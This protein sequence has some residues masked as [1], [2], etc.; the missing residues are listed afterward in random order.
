[1]FFR[2]KKSG[3]RS[4]LQIV[5]NRWAGSGARQRVIATLGR[6][7]QLQASGEL[8]SLLRSGARFS[9][10][11]MVLGAHTQGEAPAL[12]SRR[13]GPAWVF[14]RLW[15]ET[16][17]RAVVESLLTERKFEFSVERAIF[18]TVLHRLF[19]PGSDR[20]ADKWRG[21]YAM[22]G[23]EGV[24]LHHL[25]RAMAWLGEELPEDSQ[26]G[27]TP[28]A[29]RCIKD[30]I[31]EHL[32][33]RRRDLFSSL[34]LVFFDTTSIYFEGRGGETI[35]RR[36]HSKDHRPD[37]PQMVVGAV[38]D[39]EGRPVCCELWPGNTADVR[40][41]LPLVER[42]RKRFAIGEICIVAD[43]GMISQETVAVLESGPGDFQYI[44][45][46]RMRHQKEVREEVLSRPGRYQV[47]HRKG[48]HS[49]AP[50]PLAVKEVQLHG[51]RYVVCFNEDQAKK[52]AADRDAIVS[53]LRERLKRG[54]KSL[55]GNQ[56]YRKYLKTQGSRFVVDDERIQAETRFDGKWV[57]RTNT[58]LPAAEVALKYKQLWM[59]EQLFRTTKSLLATRPIFHKCDETIRGHVF[60]SF[61]ALVLRKELQDRLQAKGHDFE[62]ADVLSD[63]AA[64][65]EFDVRYQHKHFLLR[66][67]V[68][69]TC[70][71]VMQAAGVALPPTVRQLAQ[72]I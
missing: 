51:S 54:D 49:K 44:L 23:V 27:R 36:G 61:L 33:A 42:L 46:V 35:G 30:L 39:G 67:E 15:A 40:T 66:S 32:F 16:G 69:G 13:I 17:C 2:V 5:E 48:E 38:V 34:E 21:E 26:G 18:L 41:L 43:R 72:E 7:E 56:G 63:L 10:S 64:L 4:Y 62:W 9:E 47:V 60:C 52:D 24:Q 65:Q 71:K 12:D 29:P 28:F 70:G 31:E 19:D 3:P 55:V 11:V 25:Y 6:L 58:E 57:L 1:M 50:S 8:D 37:C 53:A 22:A 14:E 59:V 20:A 45:G 68:R